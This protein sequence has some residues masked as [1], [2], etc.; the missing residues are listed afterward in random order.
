M[1]ESESIPNVTRRPSTVAPMLLASI[2]SLGLTQSA[3]HLIFGLGRGAVVAKHSDSGV[4]TASRSY[5]VLKTE[6]IASRELACRDDV[7]IESI[8]IRHPHYYLVSGCGRWVVVYGGEC[9][10]CDYRLR[11]ADA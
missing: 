11:Q 10:K 7:T 9:P 5:R 6:R 3:C 1:C 4:H 8:G 2:A